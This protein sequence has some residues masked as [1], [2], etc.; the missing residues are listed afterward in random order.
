MDG[1]TKKTKDKPFKAVSPIRES[2]EGRGLSAEGGRISFCLES[3]IPDMCVQDFK[4]H[5][6]RIYLLPERGENDERYPITTD[7]KREGTLGPT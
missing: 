6:N 7:K 5:E 4:Y 1:K 3:R 2:G